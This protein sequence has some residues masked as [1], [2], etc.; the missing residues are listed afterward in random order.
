MGERERKRELERERE[1]EREREERKRELYVLFAMS[2]LNPPF[3]Q[4]SLMFSSGRS[5]FA[6]TKL[7]LFVACSSGVGSL[8]WRCFSALF[9]SLFFSSGPEGAVLSSGFFSFSAPLL[10]FFFFSSRLRLVSSRPFCSDCG[11]AQ[12]FSQWTSSGKPGLMTLGK[13][14]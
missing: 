5:Q 13:H 7:L 2:K 9:S 1:R 8:M 4:K 12:A 11:R 10:F 6:G 14:P 3:I